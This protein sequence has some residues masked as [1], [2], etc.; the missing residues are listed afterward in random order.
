MPKA[1][2]KEAAQE[3][4]PQIISSQEEGGCRTKKLLDGVLFLWVVWCDDGRKHRQQ[5]HQPQDSDTERAHWIAEQPTKHLGC[6]VV[7]RPLDFYDSANAETGSRG[8][9]GAR[10]ARRNVEGPHTGRGPTMIHADGLIGTV[11]MGLALAF[12]GGLVAIRLHL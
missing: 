3:I 8:M 6:R 11:A 2:V 4:A 12:F 9:F 5:H 10:G 7:S 1:A